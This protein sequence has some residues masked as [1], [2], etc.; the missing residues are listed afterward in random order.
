[1]ARKK[2]TVHNVELDTDYVNARL[3]LAMRRLV[4]SDCNR[5][6][7]MAV[8]SH[9]TY[10]S[11]DLMS[12]KE[13]PDK[14]SGDMSVDLLVKRHEALVAE[15]VR[16]LV[17]H[18][19]CDS[20][21]HALE[22]VHEMLRCL[23]CKAHASDPMALS[24]PALHDQAWYYAIL[25]TKHHE[26]LCFDGLIAYALDHTTVTSADSDADKTT[27]IARTH[28]YRFI[29]FPNTPLDISSPLSLLNDY[30]D[31]NTDISGGD[32]GSG[33]DSVSSLTKLGKRRA[34]TQQPGGL[35][36]VS[37]KNDITRGARLTFHI[38]NQEGDEM[39]VVMPKDD[40]F[41]KLAAYL[42][43]KRGWRTA[44]VRLVCQGECLFGNRM[45]AVNTPASRGIADNAVIHMILK[46]P[47]C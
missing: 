22:A 4:D 33:D 25:N 40:S 39:P 7:E 12:N 6:E 8:M 26:T 27:R 15:I 11:I 41:D 2:A 23:I 28:A 17:A 42:A 36:V 44:D 9:L 14:F 47:V 20:D 46:Q 3:T 19:D 34:E 10:A 29:L 21:E 5:E 32:S 1:M 35:K 38:I 37:K 45:P 30:S 24:M 16:M 13:K 43:R 31:D 18:R